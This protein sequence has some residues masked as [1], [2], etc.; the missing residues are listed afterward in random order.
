MRLC[1]TRAITFLIILAIAIGCSRSSNTRKSNQLELKAPENAEF[2]DVIPLA[3]KH[4]IPDTAEQQAG[5]DWS[6]LSQ[7]KTSCN[8]PLEQNPFKISDLSH[9]RDLLACPQARSRG[10]R[11]GQ[12]L[13]RGAG[14]RDPR[15]RMSRSPRCYRARRDQVHAGRRHGRTEG[16]HPGE[17]QA[18]QRTRLPSRPNRG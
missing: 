10:P 6:G 1:F 14:L 2:G 8:A 17:I 9:L 4:A 13:D 7:G 16:G 11:R 3:E 12:S 15:E 5:H 18:G